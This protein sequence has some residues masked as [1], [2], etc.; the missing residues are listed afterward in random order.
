MVL[1]QGAAPRVTSRAAINLVVGG[2]GF[3]ALCDIGAFSP[4]PGASRLEAHCKPG[5]GSR[6]A[7]RIGECNVLASRSM[8]GL[9][10]YIDLFIV[11]IKPVVPRVVAFLDVGAMA[12]RTAGIPIEE[13][14]RPMQRVTGCDGL[15]GVEVIPPLPALALGPGIPG[16]RECLQP[17]VAKRQQILLQG[18]N[19]KHILDRI[20][21][22]LA[23]GVIGLNE[24]GVAFLAEGRGYAKIIKGRVV[25]VAQDRLGCGLLHRQI[26]MG[27]CPVGVGPL[28]AAGTGG[29]T[30]VARF[31][32]D[33]GSGQG[34]ENHQRYQ[35]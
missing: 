14:T 23:S 30:D 8:A 29:I 31:S 24:K 5:L 34:A 26:V 20:R 22:Q 18:L 19:P 10:A 35:Y 33:R 9:T 27:A 7:S 32:L 25:E 11:G 17:A 1:A 21:F 3:T 4:L 28:M 6:Q 15:V 12:F 16:N 2:Q 13:S